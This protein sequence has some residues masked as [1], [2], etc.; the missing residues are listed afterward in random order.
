DPGSARAP[1]M[2]YRPGAARPGRRHAFLARH[3]IDALAGRIEA[4]PAVLAHLGLE[5]HPLLRLETGAASLAGHPLPLPAGLVQAMARLRGRRRA[6]WDAAVG[7]ETVDGL[8]RRRLLVSDLP[9]P[10]TDLDETA[11]LR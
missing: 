8:L 10:T 9:P 2:T 7:A 11:R 5:P 6:E 3:V 1:V 4:D